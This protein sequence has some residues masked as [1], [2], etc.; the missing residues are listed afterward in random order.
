MFDGF[1]ANI[2]SFL[3]EAGYRVI[4]A[5]ICI[6]LHE[7]AHG[8]TAFRLG[9]RTAKDM[10]RL[11]L[12][13]IKHIDVVGLL[14]MMFFWFGWAKPVPVN[15]HNF[16]K[17]KRDM[18]IT[19]IAGPVTNILITIV[20]LFIFGLAITPLGGYFVLQGD[21]LMFLTPGVGGVVLTML[22]NTAFISTALAVFNMM[23]VPPLDGSKVLFSLLPEESY[24]RLMRVERYGIIVL[25][26]FLYFFR[27]AMGQFIGWVF[28]FFDNIWMTM[29]QLVN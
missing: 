2:T 23:P 19:A 12:N 14:M 22:Y 4:P 25:V 26:L 10:G 13:P 8:Y 20:V 15:M 29:F 11:T 3:T 7:L 6:T 1:F 28:S 27:G 24:L 9:D 5:L 17:P 21:R 18:A 16:K